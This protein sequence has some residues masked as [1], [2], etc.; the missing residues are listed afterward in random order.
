MVKSDGESQVVGEQMEKSEAIPNPPPIITAA[1]RRHS[2]SPRQRTMS[3]S[4][5]RF[6]GMQKQVLGLYRGFL[7]AA[8]SKSPEDRRRIESFVSAE[9]RRNSKL[10]DRK[11][12]LYIEYL[13]RREKLH[14]ISSG[15]L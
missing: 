11:N 15:R 9:F 13:L 8:R 3:K 1:H 12:F 5:P 14:G 4:G 6:S 2:H 7:R 10:V